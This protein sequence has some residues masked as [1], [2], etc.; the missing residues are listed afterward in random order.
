M[1]STPRAMMVNT[2]GARICRLPVNSALNYSL[3]FFFITMARRNG[4]ASNTVSSA[5]SGLAKPS[6]IMLAMKSS[7]MVSIMDMT[8]MVRT[9]YIS[10]FTAICVSN[11]FQLFPERSTL[12]GAMSDILFMRLIH[13]FGRWLSIPLYIGTAPRIMY[14]VRN[15]VMTDTVTT[16]G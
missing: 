13:T 6:G 2:N 3:L 9:E 11:G 7:P 16:T 10:V 14:G 12:E 4:A 8:A 15:V 5:Q 1:A